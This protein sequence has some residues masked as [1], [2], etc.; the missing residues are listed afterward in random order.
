MRMHRIFYQC[1]QQLMS[2]NVGEIDLPVRSA[3][4]NEALAEFVGKG[5]QFGFL[6]VGTPAVVAG[7]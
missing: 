3:S 6:S 7:I 1:L 5:T 4:E 2:T